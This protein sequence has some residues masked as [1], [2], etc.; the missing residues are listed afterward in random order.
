MRKQ[1]ISFDQTE[2]IANDEVGGIDLTII[3]SA[4]EFE[5]IKKKK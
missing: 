3:E 5:R 2:I 1:C 4:S